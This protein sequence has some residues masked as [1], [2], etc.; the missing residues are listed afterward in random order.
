VHNIAC[1]IAD[2]FPNIINRYDNESLSK[3][4]A[5]I[6]QRVINHFAKNQ[7]SEILSLE[8]QISLAVYKGKCDSIE[9]RRQGQFFPDLLDRI[10]TRSRL[11]TPAGQFYRRK[12]PEIRLSH[13]FPFFQGVRKKISPSNNDQWDKYGYRIGPML[14]QLIGDYEMVSEDEVFGNIKF[15]DNHKHKN[16]KKNLAKDNSPRRSSLRNNR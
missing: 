13:S 10:I 8:H 9:L 16:I 11:L 3:A 5:G 2:S 12:R 1:S 7:N 15:V 4:G 14:D 6:A